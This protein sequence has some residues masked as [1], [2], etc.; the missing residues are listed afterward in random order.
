MITSACRRFGGDE[1]QPCSRVPREYLCQEVGSPD[2]CVTQERILERTRTA[3]ESAMGQLRCK[4]SVR[5]APVALTRPLPHHAFVPLSRR[6]HDLSS[7]GHHGPA[8]GHLRRRWQAP[9]ER[10]AAGDPGP[11]RTGLSA[12][13]SD[14]SSVA[15]WTRL[16]PIV[17]RR[18]TS[19]A[20]MGKRTGGAGVTGSEMAQRDEYLLGYRRAE[21]ER[22]QEQARQL[23]DESSWLFDQFAIASGA[24]VV[25]IGCGPQGCL[26]LLAQRVGP[27][28]SVIGVERSA[29]AVQMA[30]AMVVEHGLGNVEIVHG[31]ARVTG[32]PRGE[33]DL[34]TSRL[35][36]VNVPQPEEIIAEAVALT[37][38]GGIVAFHEADYVAHVCDPPLAAWDRAIEV[39]NTYSCSAG[40]DLFIGR[41]LPR[42]LRDAGVGEIEVRPLVHVYPPGHGRRTILLD[43]VENLSGRLVE[44]GSVAPDELEALKH[45]LRQHLDDP[46]TVVVSHLF[47]QAWG[48]K[49]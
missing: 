17:R 45:S 31:D 6:S 5:N 47:L 40:I 36:L 19:R 1:A 33:F 11:G 13:L 46:D 44:T 32:L 25:E 42:L 37:K 8:Y 4:W 23:A 43:F 20:A 38:A 35:V 9:G 10:P 48:H 15:E 3:D 21:Q 27:S 2:S 18:V 14:T 30:R 24:R 39:L 16:V 7:N 28:G 41:K 12:A 49:R 22:L 29:E 26:D 34:V